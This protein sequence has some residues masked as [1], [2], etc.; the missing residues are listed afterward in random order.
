MNAAEAIYCHVLLKY[1]QTNWLTHAI[2]A[3]PKAFFFFNGNVG[4]IS[5]EIEWK[6]EWM[7]YKG[8][9]FRSRSSSSDLKLVLDFVTIN[10]FT[11]SNVN[12]KML[13]FPFVFFI[14]IVNITKISSRLCKL[15]GTTVHER[16]IFIWCLGFGL[17]FC[18]LLLHPFTNVLL[19]GSAGRRALVQKH[20][21]A[22]SLH[23]WKDISPAPDMSLCLSP[24]SKVWRKV[25][26][27]HLENICN[28]FFHAWQGVW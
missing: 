20:V 24:K 15:I 6:V 26:L 5:Q 21:C 11:T 12:E 27:T 19:Q 28:C 9:T 10:F 8:T 22:I 17:D 23:S 7:V 18:I 16:K 2:P 1:I 4:R 14:K 13:V 3:H 25:L